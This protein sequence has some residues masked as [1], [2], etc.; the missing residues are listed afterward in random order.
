MTEMRSMQRIEQR[1]LRHQELKRQ[2]LLV[3]TAVNS[4]AAQEQ[5][6]YADD[7]SVT[8][9]SA[10]TYYNC[11]GTAS[12]F[13]KLIDAG[14]AGNTPAF[15][16]T[17]PNPDDRVSAINSRGDCLKCN[18]TPVNDAAYSQFKKDIK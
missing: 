13:Q 2:C 8:Y 12:F 7:Y 16:S 10:T 3:A 11:K 6:S 9:L 14:Q 5:Q 18:T 4:H 1:R 17:H 15:L